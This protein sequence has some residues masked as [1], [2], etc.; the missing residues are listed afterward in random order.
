[1]IAADVG[2]QHAI[3]DGEDVREASVRHRQGPQV[4]AGGGHDQR[5]PVAV[6]ADVTDDNVDNAISM[7]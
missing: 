1:M 5:G 4:G 2:G 6:P 3:D 7:R